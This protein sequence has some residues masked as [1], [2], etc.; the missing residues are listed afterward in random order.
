MIIQESEQMKIEPSTTP[1]KIKI[2]CLKCGNMFEI[3]ALPEDPPLRNFMLN[4]LE[5]TRFCPDCEKQLQI[6]ADLAASEAR[7][8]TLQAT[9]PLRLAGSGMPQKYTHDRQTGNLFT[10]PPKRFA[11]E[12]FWRNR[13][14]NL[15]ISGETGTGKSTS[16]CFVATKLLQ[17]GKRIRY[18]Q[19]FDLLAEWREAKT[20][21]RSN[22]ASQML[23]FYLNQLDL[24]IIDELAGKAKITESGQELLFHILESVYNGCC[25]T[26]IWLLGNFYNGSIEDIF[27][28]GGPARRRL[29]ECFQCVRL[30]NDNNIAELPVA[31]NV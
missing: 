31:V 21:D 30:T 11:A 18:R 1:D 28:D 7:K 8:A 6:E 23:D 29:A 3:D 22:A 16:A 26:T 4:F 19:A 17:T 27:P 25:K 9:F 5:N 15:L 2:D 10:E 24:L 13:R 12:F 20:S 14:N